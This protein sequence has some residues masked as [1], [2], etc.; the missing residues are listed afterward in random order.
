[1]PGHSK[2]GASLDARTKKYTGSHP[3]LDAEEYD[4]AEK[5]YSEILSSFKQRKIKNHY[6]KKEEIDQDLQEAKVNHALIIGFS[7]YK[8]IGDVNIDLPLAVKDA[9]GANFFFTE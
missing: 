2:E 8:S 6:P 3:K 1:M 7:K 4:K 9:L 5:F